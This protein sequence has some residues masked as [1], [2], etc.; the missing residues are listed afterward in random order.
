VTVHPTY[1]AFC[2]D[3]GTEPRACAPCRAQTKGKGESGVKYVKRNALAGRAFGSFA[4]LEAHLGAWMGEAD[5]REH[6]TT[7][8][9]P[10]V[11]FEREER[12]ALRP[13]PARPLPRREQRLRRRVAHDALVDVDT[14]RYSVPH[15]L[16]RDHVE[17]LVG[18]REVRIF[19][20]T[21]LVAVHARSFEPHARV[22]DPAHYAG[23]WRVVT[24]PELVPEVETGA[25]AHLG[26]SLADYAAVIEVAR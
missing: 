9:E 7:H 11:R 18:D 26:R 2:R 21:D 10:I 20:G 16:V 25:L 4:A 17:V 8:E 5:R 14:V 24:E 13:L 23:L 6:G 3:F 15:R 1:L 12:A 19:H 22:V